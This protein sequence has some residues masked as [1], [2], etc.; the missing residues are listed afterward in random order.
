[1]HPCT[2]EK[3]AGNRLGVDPPQRDWP[4]RT[5][6][7]IMTDETIQKAGVILRSGVEAGRI[8]E[9][10][11]AGCSVGLSRPYTAHSERPEAH[12][13]ISEHPDVGLCG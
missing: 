8:A 10:G 13:Q 11:E 12:P 3:I 6:R 7:A 2:L 4:E 1:M 5:D 9:I